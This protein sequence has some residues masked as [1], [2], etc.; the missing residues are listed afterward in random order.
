MG[1]GHL[2]TMEEARSRAEASHSSRRGKGSQANQEVQP[3]SFS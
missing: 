2:F 3:A 1:I